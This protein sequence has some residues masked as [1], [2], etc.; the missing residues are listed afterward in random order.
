MRRKREIE[1]LDCEPI[2]GPEFEEA[3]RQVLLSPKPEGQASEN[4]EPTRAELD[5]KFKLTRRG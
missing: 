2:T 4:R 5:Q 1:P 3:V